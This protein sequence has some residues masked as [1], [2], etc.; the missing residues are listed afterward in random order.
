MRRS[1]GIYDGEDQCIHWN[2]VDH[3]DHRVCCGGRE[4]KM[5][6]IKC[7]KKGIVLAETICLIYCQDKCIKQGEI[8]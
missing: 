1:D 6:L 3:I 4:M 7:Q 5:A 8:R 2:G